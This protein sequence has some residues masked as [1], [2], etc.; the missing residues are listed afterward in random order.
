MP[1]IQGSTRAP[2]APRAGITFRWGKRVS[3]PGCRLARR[4]HWVSRTWWAPEVADRKTIDLTVEELEE[5]RQ[6]LSYGRTFS[7]KRDGMTIVLNVPA[8]VPGDISLRARAV[9]AE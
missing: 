7:I 9:R 4:R 1:V 8:G 2:T 5:L 6:F 3:S